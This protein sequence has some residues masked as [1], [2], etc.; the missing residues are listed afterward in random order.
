MTKLINDNPAAD[1]PGQLPAETGF[2]VTSQ[3]GTASLYGRDPSCTQSARRRVDQPTITGRSRLGPDSI[4]V[5]ASARPFTGSS[6]IPRC[7]SMPAG[8]SRRCRGCAARPGSCAC[9]GALPNLE[10]RQFRFASV[11]DSDRGSTVRVPMMV[12]DANADWSLRLDLSRPAS[13]PPCPGNHFNSAD[14]PSVRVKRM[15]IHMVKPIPMR[16]SGSSRIAAGCATRGRNDAYDRSLL[17]IT[18]CDLDRICVEL[19]R[20]SVQCFER[21][22]RRFCSLRSAFC[23]TD[24]NSSL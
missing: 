9:P 19:P 18:S 16:E 17:R 21:S 5:F 15:V 10:D 1:G 3:P 7:S 2:V 24:I 8:G 11:S 23:V 13:P 4:Q 14:V 6:M 12:R 22:R 20:T